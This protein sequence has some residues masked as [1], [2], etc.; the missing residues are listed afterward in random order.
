M[1]EIYNLETEREV[2][3][4]YCKGCGSEKKP[5][6]MDEIYSLSDPRGHPCY[7]ESINNEAY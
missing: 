4:I 3:P 7:I 1:A 6:D 2:I 5:D